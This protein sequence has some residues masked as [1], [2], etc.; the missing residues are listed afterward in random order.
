MIRVLV[1]ASS[2]RERVRLDTLVRRSGVAELV[3]STGSPGDWAALAHERS[4]DVIVADS[5]EGAADGVPGLVLSAEPAKLEGSVCGTLHPD[6]SPEEMAAALRAVE[7]GLFVF[8]PAHRASPAALGS[9]ANP[10]SPRESEVL[11]RLAE[12][13]GNKVIAGM[14]GISENTVKFHVSSIME[15]LEAGSR[16]EAVARGLRQGLVVV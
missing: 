13:L 8:H 12:G 11:A 7:A 10:L 2:Q 15:K 5:P 16:T 14:L 1:A 9:S 4:P 3:S 6:A